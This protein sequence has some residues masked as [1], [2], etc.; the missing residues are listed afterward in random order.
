L[1]CSEAC[2]DH[3]NPANILEHKGRGIP[4][5]FLFWLLGTTWV[6]FTLAQK[7]LQFDSGSQTNKGAHGRT[8][9]GHQIK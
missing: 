1:R 9:T 6:L 4:Q 5:Y 2:P 3:A 8:W 7:W